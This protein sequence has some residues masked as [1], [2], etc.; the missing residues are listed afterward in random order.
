MKP[1]QS[2]PAAARR[3]FTLV[4]LLTVIAIIAV[5]TAIL[6]PVFAQ[7][8]KG[9]RKAACTQNIH[10]II[11]ALKMYK[12]DWR[13]YPDALYGVVYPQHPNPGMR[14][15][16]I[17]LADDYVKDPGVFSCP[18]HPAQLKQSQNFRPA[19]NP[20]TQNTYTSRRF[21]VVGLAER[22]SYDGQFLS[23]SSVAANTPMWV[24][25]NPNWTIGTG[26]GTDPRQ[27]IYREP[28]DTTVVTWCLYHSGRN[29]FGV[30]GQ[31]EVALVGFLSGRVQTLDARRVAIWGPTCVVAPPR[32]PVDCP[33]QIAPKP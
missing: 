1:P 23:A 6:F 12:D 2:R 3:G 20:M 24:H 26:V 25:Y 27:L 17:R 10:Q 4:E 15:P 9:G 7:V 19:F 13:V 5:L 14:L 28:P 29:A 22:S 30:P 8:R 16:G 32:V 33:W 31:G 18:E 21:G 11:Q